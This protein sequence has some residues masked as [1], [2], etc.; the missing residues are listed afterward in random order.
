MIDIN[1]KKAL[2]EALNR[3]LKPGESFQI[4]GNGSILTVVEPDLSVFDEEDEPKR[5]WLKHLFK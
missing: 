2:I 5:G 4:Q 3:K 1:D